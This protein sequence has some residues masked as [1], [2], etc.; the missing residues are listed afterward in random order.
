LF[1]VQRAGGEVLFQES[2][3]AG[4][5]SGFR[6]RFSSCRFSFSRI[7]ADADRF[8]ILRAVVFGESPARSALTRNCLKRISSVFPSV[9]KRSFDIAAMVISVGSRFH[10]SLVFGNFFFIVF[11]CESRSRVKQAVAASAVFCKI[12]DGLRFLS[13][14][15][16]APEVRLYAYQDKC[17]SS[18]TASRRSGAAGQRLALRSSKYG[19]NMSRKAPLNVAARSSK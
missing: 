3:R 16:N 13:F 1:L 14:A 7:R 6:V 18:A 10:A 4:G 11:Q 5:R 9:S 12:N 19:K 2:R 17:V 15:Q 8:L